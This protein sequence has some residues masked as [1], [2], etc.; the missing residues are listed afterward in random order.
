MHLAVLEEVDLSVS[1][2]G[3]LK[4]DHAH[5][6]ALWKAMGELE[7]EVRDMQET[8]DLLQKE[9]ITKPRAALRV[10]M[11]FFAGVVFMGLLTF[12]QRVSPIYPILEAYYEIVK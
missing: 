9:T 4:M 6:L 1:A 12:D 10:G 5:E 7:R 3:D 11:A 8:F 2:G